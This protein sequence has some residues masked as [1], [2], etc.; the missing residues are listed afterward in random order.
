MIEK[1]LNKGFNL[2][3]L[4]DEQYDW[5]KEIIEKVLFQ[6]RITLLKIRRNL[7][8]KSN[9]NRLGKITTGPMLNVFEYLEPKGM[10][11]NTS[12]TKV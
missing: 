8:T 4:S 11:R 5:L 7:P 1:V 2:S 10:I 3:L 6:D 9:K 12:E